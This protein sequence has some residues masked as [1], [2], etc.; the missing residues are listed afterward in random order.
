[1]QPTAAGFFIKGLDMIRQNSLQEYTDLPIGPRLFVEDIES[2][3]KVRDVNPAAVSDV[4]KE[5]YLD[6]SEDSIQMA[7]E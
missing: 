3:R 2:F 1:L 7:L 6:R 5:G 4:L